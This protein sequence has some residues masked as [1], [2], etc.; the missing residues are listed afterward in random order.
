MTNRGQ[1]EREREKRRRRGGLVEGEVQG[2]AEEVQVHELPQDIPGLVDIGYV[3]VP[4]LVSPCFVVS[5]L[6]V[7]SCG[8]MSWGPSRVRPSTGRHVFVWRGLCRWNIA[9]DAMMST[10]TLPSF[11][12]PNTSCATSART[13][14]SPFLSFEPKSNARRTG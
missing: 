1:R 10:F 6:S 4:L 5:L 8:G 11:A 13:C 3:P 14:T 7:S 12:A 9:M 2:L